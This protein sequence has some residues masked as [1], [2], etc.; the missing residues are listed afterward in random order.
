VASIWQGAIRAGAIREGCQRQAGCQG[1]GGGIGVCRSGPARRL[2]RGA[3]QDKRRG[4]ASARNR[5]TASRGAREWQ[6]CKQCA[7]LERTLLPGA[8]F[9]RRRGRAATAAS[10]LQRWHGGVAVPMP[11]L[12][13][14][15]SFARACEVLV[16][17]RH[18]G[19]HVVLACAPWLSQPRC[20]RHREQEARAG[21]GGAQSG[22]TRGDARE[23]SAARE[24]RGGRRTGLQRGRPRH[25]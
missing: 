16:G 15:P 12:R 13:C 21:G 24:D 3:G 14:R 19:R 6:R 5:C 11:C 2:G 18:R 20:L 25:R 23:D 8:S 10:L 22:R 7:R 9:A 17:A 4:G 1:W